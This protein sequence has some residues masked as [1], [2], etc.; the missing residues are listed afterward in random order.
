VSERIVPQRKTRLFLI[1]LVHTI[2][3]LIISACILYILYAGLR[4]ELT[5]LIGVA[6]IVVIAE[7]LIYSLNGFR[8]PMTALAKRY[9][10]EEGH[11]LIA[12]IFLPQWFIPLVVPVCTLLAVTGMVAVVVT[13]LRTAV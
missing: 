1:K 5:P 2:L 4:G 6:M 8:C 9:G 13:W 12:D 7:I 11:D 10:D 3:F